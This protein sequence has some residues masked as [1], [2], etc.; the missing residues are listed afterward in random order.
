MTGVSS[1]KVGLE[2]VLGKSQYLSI[3]VIHLSYGTR[4]YF[5]YSYVIVSS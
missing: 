4:F 1:V 3:R 2:A 5:Q